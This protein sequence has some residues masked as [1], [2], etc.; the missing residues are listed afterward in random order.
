MTKN[1]KHKIDQLSPDERTLI[2]AK[3]KDRINQ[4]KKVLDHSSNKLVAYVQP[5]DKFDLDTFKLELKKVLPE[6][7]VPTSI[8]VMETMPLL[9][10]GKIDR[11]KLPEIAIDNQGT[12]NGYQLLKNNEIESKLI[13]IWEEVLHFSPI[14][15]KDNFFEIGGDSILSIQIIAK[16]RKA[17][18]AISPNQLFDHQTIE[19]LANAILSTEKKLDEETDYLVTLRKGGDKKPLFCIHSG[20]GHVFFYNHLTDH[21]KE[22]RPIYALQASGLNGNK[23][24]MHNSIEEM[25]RDYL[26]TIRSIQPEGPYNILVYCFSTA[27]GNEMAIQLGKEEQETN[28]IVMDTMA[29]P[30]VVNTKDR[31]GI[32]KK[33]FFKRFFR[34]PINAIYRFLA[35]R[36]WMIEP[37]RVKLFGKSHEKDLE[38]LKANLRKIC[39]AYEW[40]KHPGHASLILTKKQDESFQ[41]LIVNSWEKLSKGGVSVTYTKGK[42]HTLF[43]K[44]DIKYVSEKIDT[45]I[46]D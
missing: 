17:G 12:Q 35:D 8:K 42:H 18:I 34:N 19:D 24:Y 14:N 11:N 3:L 20:G 29:S 5:N 15:T 25:S 41:N 16:A 45:C 22:G 39:V 6:F 33:A 1:I 23:K 2:F 36:T 43:E 10:N 9:P 46:I 37:V 7:M 28:I 21:L 4:N 32:R 40:K 30:W 38:K 13:K 27:V 26:K 31:I 44:S